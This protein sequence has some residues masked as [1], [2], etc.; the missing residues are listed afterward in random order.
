MQQLFLPAFL[1]FLL[2][3]SC[4]CLSGGKYGRVFVRNILVRNPLFPLCLVRLMG[5]MRR[6]SKLYWTII[7]LLGLS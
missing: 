3:S 1:M 7:V 5:V 2:L 4:Y 6:H